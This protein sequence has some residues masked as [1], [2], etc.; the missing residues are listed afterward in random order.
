MPKDDEEESLVEQ[1]HHK[2]IVKSPSRR[3]LKCYNDGLIISIFIFLLLVGLAISLLVYVKSHPGW[4]DGL[5]S[6]SYDDRKHHQD[7]VDRINAEQ[8]LW[9]AKYNPNA[10]RQNDVE[11][12]EID[13]EKM[14]ERQ[15]NET[16]EKALRDTRT[17]LIQLLGLRDH[18]PKT[19]DARRRWPDCQSMR[20]ILDQAGCGSCWAASAASVMSD[21]ICIASNG[22][23]QIQ[24]SVEDLLTCCP[25]CGGCL[26]S[27]HSISPFIHFK[28]HG[29]V[30]GGEF[31]S[32]VG[33]KPYSF[34]PNCGSPCSPSNFD[35]SKTPKCSK[36]CRPDYEKTY[37]E[38]LIRASQ[39]YWVLADRSLFRRAEV[40]PLLLKLHLQDEYSEELIKR[41]IYHFGPI[42]ACMTVHEQFQ[43]YEY[44]IYSS[45]TFSNAI[46]GHC[47]KLLGWGEQD[48]KEYWLYANSWGKSWGENGFIRINMKD[49]ILHASAGLL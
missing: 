26:G 27:L 11:P 22:K 6:H 37:E 29:I 24:I 39:A 42:Q 30:T 44:G 18:L 2:I 45:G 21:R 20:Q 12:Y 48:G 13:E 25:H 16:S 47:M 1:K 15:R 19:F 7:M 49:A 14:W 31:N 33:C 8:N 46:Y 23:R 40:W 3:R 5:I 4:V 43:H 38:D 17:H 41:E 36:Q 28:E 32:N 35:S 9:R 34:P 10:A